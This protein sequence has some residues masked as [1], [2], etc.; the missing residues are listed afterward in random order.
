[1][2]GRA[3]GQ[4]AVAGSPAVGADVPAIRACVPAAPSEQAAQLCV[5][6]DAGRP[7]PLGTALAVHLL[8]RRGVAADRPIRLGAQ[9]AFRAP[10]SCSAACRPIS[11]VYAGGIDSLMPSRFIHGTPRSARASSTPEKLP[12]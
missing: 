9:A 1:M 5:R 6:V 3:V 12:T 2:V 10:W 4:S 8:G 11:S 7:A